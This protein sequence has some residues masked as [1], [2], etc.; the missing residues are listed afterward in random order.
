[1][2]KYKRMFQR[3]NPFAVMVRLMERINRVCKLVSAKERHVSSERVQVQIASIGCCCTGSDT[4]TFL[5]F[6]AMVALRY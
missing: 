2:P 5:S 6:G 4:N 3:S 1:M